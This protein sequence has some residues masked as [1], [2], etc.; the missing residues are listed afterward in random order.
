[1]VNFT[2]DEIRSLMDVPTNIRNMSVIAHVDHGKSTLSDSL[3]SHAGIIAKAAAGDTRFMQTRADEQARTITIKCSS[4][5]LFFEMHK[6]EVNTLD[7][8]AIEAAAKRAAEKEAN[9]AKEAEDAK[10]RDDAK[11]AEA[12]E[13]AKR[14]AETG[15]Y[16]DVDLGISSSG[17]CDDGEEE[18]DAEANAEGEDDN[19]GD[20]TFVPTKIIP[21]DQLVKNKDNRPF[22]INL[23]DSPGHVDFSS[24]VTAALRVTDGALVVVDCV[25]GVCVQTETVLRQAIMERIRPVVFVNKVD[26]LFLELQADLEEAYQSFS[27]AIESVNVVV[28]TYDDG[29]FGDNQVYPERGTVGF[30]SGKMAWGF[31]LKK[32]AKM[33][34]SKF[35]VPEDKMITQLWGE[36]YLCPKTKKII[37]KPVNSEGKKAERCFVSFVL[38]PI[39][40]IFDCVK[41]EKQAVLSETLTK[42]GINLDKEQRDL[43]GTAL[44]KAIMMSW[45]P[46]AESLLQ[47]IVNHLPSPAI[48][49]RYRVGSLY[50]GPMDDECA[51]AIARCDQNGPLMLYVSKMFPTSEKGRFY[52]FGRVFSGIVRTGQT[53]RI[54]GPDYIPG[55]KNDL[56]VKKVQRTVLLM[57]RYIEQ[58]SDCPCGNIIGLVGID[59]YLVKSGTLTTHEKAHNFH[60]M[61]FSVSPVVRVAVKVA[62][63]AD[64]PKLAEG[65]KRLAKSDPM[66][67]IVQNPD[68]KEHIIAGA[69]SLHLEICLKD[70]QDDFMKG[71]K[72]VISD[73]V[74]NFAETIQGE[75]EGIVLT[76]SPNG[77]NRIYLKGNPL[78]E[79]LSKALENNEVP[80]NEDI[81]TCA[82]KLADDYGW[83]VSEARKIW[84]FGALPDVVTNCIVDATKAV[85]YLSEIKDSVCTAFQQTICKGVLCNENM[86]GIRFNLTDVT[87]HADAIHRGAGQLMPPVTR[88]M[89][90][91]QLKSQPAIL[92]PMYQC[93]VTVTNDFL[94]GV[95][96]TFSQRRGYV[97][98]EVPRA[99]TPMVNVRG[100]LPVVE[101]LVKPDFTDLLRQNTKG[102]AFPQMLFSHWQLVNGSPMEAGSQANK[103]TLEV[104]KRKGLGEDLPKV[105]D[106]FDKL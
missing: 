44:T 5:S 30:G 73:P 40:R 88:A 14:A 54:Q 95:Y 69:G 103:I 60:V 86:R 25:E 13:K 35:G 101:S 79:E 18:Y 21:L 100:Y 83:D 58:L 64:L 48:A 76:K 82:R 24:E 71:A 74:V 75:T 57:G 98:E 27:R 91:V 61:K 63:A 90:G 43:T 59:Q 23:I 62:N 46:A 28:A 77:H 84:A 39:K 4:V 68:T 99:G 65:L 10:K 26:R 3:I 36:H 106:Y 9:A 1:M 2:V 42:L 34:A 72:L 49:Q 94:S 17:V 37:T 96:G 87:L 105:A 52:A 38:A 81:K 66:V 8:K 20:E 45:L 11:A 31:T 53:V 29:R 78:G 50:N 56:F 41:E 19:K 22:L 89:Y 32:F 6:D 70:L 7:D 92:E 15:D 47:M 97:T 67:H 93:D 12:A 102:K 51:Q 33:Y 85:A 55:K 104:R 80:I 16:D